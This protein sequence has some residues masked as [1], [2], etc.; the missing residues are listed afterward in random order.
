M[1]HGSGS[2]TTSNIWRHLKKYHKV[3]G[4]EEEE[5]VGAKRKIKD[6]ESQSTL[7]D[8]FRVQRLKRA[9]VAQGDD[10]MALLRFVVSLRL[11]FCTLD[12]DIFRSLSE[13]FGVPT[14]SSTHLV[15]F[16][17][18]KAMESMLAFKE[19]MVCDC[20]FHNTSTV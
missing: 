11:A 10:K 20:Y 8:A 18:Q 1:C 14:C 7:H 16:L 19:V 3:L 9:R 12:G 13:R 2:S 17:H 15:D 6:D 5:H 4:K